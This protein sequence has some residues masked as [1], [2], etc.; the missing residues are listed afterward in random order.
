M[1]ILDKYKYSDYSIGF[2][3]C[4]GILFTDGN[5]GRNVILFGADMSPSAHIVNENKCILI[6]G[7][8]PTQR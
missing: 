1:L 4:S 8:G 6:L 5:F 3:S 2:D 7:E